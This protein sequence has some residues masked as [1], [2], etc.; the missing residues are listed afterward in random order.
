MGKSFQIQTA[1]QNNYSLFLLKQPAFIFS[2]CVISILKTT[3]P[4]F[5]VVQY[6]SESPSRGKCDMK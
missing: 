1:V 5:E 4:H 2:V 3:M 6:E